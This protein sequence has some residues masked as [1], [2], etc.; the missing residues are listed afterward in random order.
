MTDHPSLTMRLII[1]KSLGLVFG[2][3][4]F[5]A[6]PDSIPGASPMLAWGLL[7]WMI[8]IGLMV[9]LIGVVTWHPVLKI[10]LPWW[11][12]APLVGS[13]MNF[14]LAF[15][16]YDQLQASIIHLMGPDS[17]FQSPFWFVLDGAI[18]GLVIGY[19]AT[20]FGGEGKE[21]VDL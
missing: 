7:F 16:I 5:F 6:L 17:F 19:F 13:W 20:R 12:R 9:G 11:V 8:N 15:L 21:S 3:I 1:G 14:I 4:T 2:I 18:I 10:R